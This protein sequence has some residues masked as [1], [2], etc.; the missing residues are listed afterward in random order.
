[1]Q[2][3]VQSYYKKMTYASI[4]HSFH[5]FFLFKTRHNDNYR[6]DVN[7]DRKGKGRK[8]S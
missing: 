3:S 1:M 4:C 8:K 5:D 2:I 7:V 6:N